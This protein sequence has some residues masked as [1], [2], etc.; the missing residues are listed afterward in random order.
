LGDHALDQDG[1][2]RVKPSWSISLF[3]RV[4]QTYG[5][6]AFSHHALATGWLQNDEA[7]LLYHII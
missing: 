6:S 3:D 1:F 4:I 2:R 5:D 7:I